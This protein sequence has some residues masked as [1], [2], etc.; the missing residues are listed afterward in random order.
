MLLSNKSVWKAAG[1]YRSGYLRNI[2]PAFNISRM[3]EGH[4]D[5][6]ISVNSISTLAQ[7]FS[8]KIPKGFDRYFRKP[9]DKENS[10]TSTEAAKESNKESPKESTS[11][12]DSSF[13][14]EEKPKTD[15]GKGKKQGGFGGSKPPDFPMGFILTSGALLLLLASEIGDLTGIPQISW[16]DFRVLLLETGQVDTIVISNKTIAKVYVRKPVDSSLELAPPSSELGY[17]E[18]SSISSFPSSSSSNP[19]P[20]SKFSRYP[21]LGGSH[22]L[23]EPSF[24]FN[25]G[26]V[27]NFEQKLEEAQKEV[28]I[29]PRDFIPV[30]YVTDYNWKGE[31]FKMLPSLLMIG[32]G[33]FFFSRMSGMGGSGG[34]GNIFK[35]GKS[36][37]KKE[38]VTTTFADVAGCD[39][40]KR[41]IMEFVQF[42]KDP[43]KFTD[44]GA[45]IPKGALLCGPPGTGKTMLAKATAGESNVP[46]YSISGSD[47]VE[48]FVGVGPS[49]VR[50]LFSEAR[51]NAPCIIF[52]D[53]ID[54]VGRQRGREGV[55]GNDERENTLNQLLVE[56]DGFDA[57][58]N[59]V[60]LAGTNR[61]DVL[62]AALT[63]PGRFDR[64]IQVDKP[65]IKGRKAIFEV[66]LKNIT[67]DGPVENYSA[68]LAALTPGFVGADI[69]NICNEA[70]I[71]AARRDKTKVD[72]VDFEMATDRI[73]GGLES[74]KIMT[75]EEKRVVAYHEAGH[76]VAGWNLEHADP[77][78]KVTIVPRG[79]GAL[80]FAQYLPKELFLRNKDQILDMVCMALAG[81]AS[82]QI[83]FGKVTTGAADDLRRVTQIVYQMVQVYGMNER[84]GQLA[85]PREESRWPQDKLYSNAT[86][87]VMDEEVRITVEQ[88]YKRTLDLMAEK[89]EQ[90]RLVAEL[91][92]EKLIGVRPFAG[93]KEYA[94]YIA[95]G[96]KKTEVLAE[97]TPV[98]EKDNNGGEHGSVDG[99]LINPAT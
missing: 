98:A 32:L 19:T 90:V 45:K 67:L 10:S 47:F 36:T 15:S 53:E 95:L 43:K 87:E 18:S 42:L 78:L 30:M 28:G 69:A 83:N 8:E 73:I 51:D 12:K 57:S 38:K 63:R 80:G 97:T 75:L 24:Y 70:A 58:T 68:R 64:Q 44:L 96:W 61:V 60:V 23:G 20:P 35:I 74:K 72:M 49:R 71:V 2:K 89:K 27:E 84:V 22:R 34:P 16:K 1:R 9:G 54:A 77:L 5:L 21:S 26:N 52:I 46:F 92:M 82:E 41:E 50:D 93:S 86:A 40:A 17:Q 66:Y 91:L 3:N 62:D 85:F 7:L 25:I 56:M 11:E 37:A 14:A 55:G 33:L 59:V 13:K 76:A 39:E 31:L 94:E 65:D 6:C 79:S 88:A 48:M 99:G 29:Q 4:P 81:R